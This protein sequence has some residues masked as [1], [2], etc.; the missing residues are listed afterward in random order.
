MVLQGSPDSIDI[1]QF[2]VRTSYRRRGYGFLL[3]A[4]VIACLKKI[5]ITSIF[6]EVSIKNDSAIAL[7][8]KLGMKKVSVR[9][10]Y[11][12]NGDDALVLQKIS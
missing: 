3:L 4:Q 7:Y 11:Y 9:K 6:L 12:S 8:R 2:F 1:I 5:G 10:N